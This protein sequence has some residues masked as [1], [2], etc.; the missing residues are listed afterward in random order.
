MQNHADGVYLWSVFGA[1]LG[2]FC[3]HCLNFKTF[4]CNLGQL[5]SR[6]QKFLQCS[7]FLQCRNFMEA[8]LLLFVVISF[9][10]CCCFTCGFTFG[11]L[12][13]DSWYHIILQNFSAQICLQGHQ[14]LS[15]VLL[16][17]RDGHKPQHATRPSYQLKRFLKDPY[18][19]VDTQQN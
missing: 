12:A 6:C 8:V 13:I 3:V 11:G 4:C 15:V 9:R 7:T 14:P 17:I 2:S 18:A 16:Y 10:S 1:M 19:R 5:A